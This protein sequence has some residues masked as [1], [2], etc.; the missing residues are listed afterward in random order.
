MVTPATEKS[1]SLN[2]NEKEL[3]IKTLLWYPLLGG[4]GGIVGQRG[5]HEVKTGE[6][7]ALLAKWE[8][9]RIK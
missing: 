8:R 4:K 7:K 9:N 5:Y 6:R 2:G 3:N 1:Y